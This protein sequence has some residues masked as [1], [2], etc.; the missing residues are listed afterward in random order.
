M[1]KSMARAYLAAE[2][3]IR[4][5]EAVLHTIEKRTAHLSEPW[6]N[7]VYITAR[8]ALAKPEEPTSP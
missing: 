6:G 1:E 3:R 5:L 4:V 7:E 2:A 8:A